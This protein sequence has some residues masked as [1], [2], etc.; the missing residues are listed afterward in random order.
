MTVFGSNRSEAARSLG[1]SRG[2]LLHPLKKYRAT[3]P[4]SE[5]IDDAAEKEPSAMHVPADRPHRGLQDDGHFLGWELEN[6]AQDERGTSTIVD[7]FERC[8]Q[9]PGQV[10]EFRGSAFELCP[11]THL[12]RTPPIAARPLPMREGNLH[13]DPI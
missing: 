3:L 13:R 12:E 9:R 8:A 6:V 1:L 5:A 4:D 2:S 7:A 11:A 10:V